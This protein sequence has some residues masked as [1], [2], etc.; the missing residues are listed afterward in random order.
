MRDL[1]VIIF[2]W[3]VVAII[4]MNDTILDTGLGRS[5]VA[6]VVAAIIVGIINRM[7]IIYTQLKTIRE[8]LEK[9]KKD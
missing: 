8:I 5:I 1:G 9:D 7:Q 2:C 4:A 3:T 6:G